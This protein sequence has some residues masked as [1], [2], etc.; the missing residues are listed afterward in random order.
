MKINFWE[1]QAVLNFGK[2]KKEQL[3]QFSNLKVYEPSSPTFALYGSIELNAQN[4]SKFVKI[5]KTKS[6]ILPQ[7]WRFIDGI[8]DIAEKSENEKIDVVGMVFDIENEKEITVGR[9]HRKR[10]TTVRS[11]KLIDQTGKITVSCWGEKSKIQLQEH[12]IIAIKKARISNYGGKSLTVLGYIEE[13]PKHVKVKELKTWKQTQ[14]LMLARLIKETKSVT[15]ESGMSRKHDYSKAK[16]T[17]VSNVIDV[18]DTF[19]L[20][21][22]LPQ[23]TLFIVP[24]KIK[25]INNNM[26]FQKA[27]KPHWR[28]KIQILDP[29]EKENQIWVTAFQTPASK[30]LDDLSPEAAIKMQTQDTSAFTSM[31]T[32]K[33]N[34]DTYNF[35]LFAKENEW[36]DMKR[37]EFIVED[38]EKQ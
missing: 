17:T 11:F 32:S 3:Y 25:K 20:T 6:F 26:F 29:V 13:N 36:Q 28:L 35:H 18:R 19:H 1:S 38:V 14:K 34:A 16:T 5:E 4:H 27:N 12:Q 9:D 31:I 7:Y 2:F 8:E 30:I 33:F 23:Q 10:P 24:A 37:L 21:N 15:D 22:A